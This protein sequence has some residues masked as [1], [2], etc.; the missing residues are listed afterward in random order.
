MIDPTVIDAFNNRL[1]VNPNSIKSLTVEQQ[2]RIK[3]HGDNA[4]NLLK[5]KD[6]AMFIH[7]LKFNWCDDL[8]S[9]KGHTDEDN[10]KR[11]AISNK[12]AAIDDFVGLLK[13]A[14]HTKASVVKANQLPTDLT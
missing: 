14:V 2:D 5:N 4:A 3:A 13:T 7:Q 6:L 8:A 1:T 11:V 10:N 12:I 9:I